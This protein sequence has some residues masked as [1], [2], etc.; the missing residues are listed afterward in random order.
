MSQFDNNNRIKQIS[1]TAFNLADKQEKE[2]FLEAIEEWKCTS[3]TRSAE[4]IFR[5]K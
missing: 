2:T 4:R 5:A 1:I 3:W